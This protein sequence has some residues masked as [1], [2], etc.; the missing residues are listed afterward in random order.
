MVSTPCDRASA[1]SSLERVAGRRQQL[2]RLPRVAQVVGAFAEEAEPIAANVESCAHAVPVL[3]RCHD[4]HRRRQLEPADARERVGDHLTLD[5]ELT[6]IRD[7]TEQAAAAERIGKRFAAIRRRFVDRQCLG[8]RD[9]LAHAVQRGRA[10]ARREWRPRPAPPGRP[11]ERSSGRRR[12]AC[13]SSAGW[14]GQVSESRESNRRQSAAL[15]DEPIDRRLARPPERLGRH[16]AAKGRQIR[17]GFARHRR[18]A[19]RFVQRRPRLLQQF[20][21][22]RREAFD[23]RVAR[24]ASKAAGLRSR[25]VQLC[26]NTIDQRVERATQRAAC[27][28]RGIRRSTTRSRCAGSDGRRDQLGIRDW[29]ATT[30]PTAVRQASKASSTSASQKSI[31][32]GRRRGPLEYRSK[33]R[34]MPLNATFNGTPRAAQLV[35]S[36]KEGPT[37]RIRCP[38]FFRQR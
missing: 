3:G 18:S 19:P 9:A 36:S 15:A 37:T 2:T 8:I 29:S 35:T 7:V 26:R 10:R 34:S 25:R 32:T 6:G 16:A 17:I 12:R 1:T 23:Q 27:A 20:A 31:F 14:S 22:E 21:V 4:P 38:S 13:R 33:Y 24:L 28:R 30:T 11:R 5:L